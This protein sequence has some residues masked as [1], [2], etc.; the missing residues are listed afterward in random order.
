MYVNQFQDG[1]RLLNVKN[2]YYPEIELN[3]FKLLIFRVVIRLIVVTFLLCIESSKVFLY[4]K[5]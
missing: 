3:T 4:P 1:V 5:C 2:F